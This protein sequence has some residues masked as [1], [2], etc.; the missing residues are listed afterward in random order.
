MP[1]SSPAA[2]GH[3]GGKR[4]Y[5]SPVRRERAEHTQERVSQA[6][7]GLFADRG[8]AR[9]SVRDIANAAGVAVE[10]VYAS[11]PK[12][13]VFL[14]AFELSLRGTLDGTPLLELDP[15]RAAA[16]ARSLAE[17]LTVITDFV[18]AANARTVRLWR[19]FVEAANGDPDVARAYADQ[20]TGMRRQ[21]AEV[22]AF[23]V[24]RQ[25]C[26]P[27]R[28]PQVTLDAVWATLH[29]SQYDL[30]VRHAGW[31]HERYQ[32]WLISTVTDLLARG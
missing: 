25:L 18:V 1:P 31:D 17:F 9:T 21:G 3:D 8:Y 16:D 15:V 6:A 27:P 10:T 22:L 11:G 28:A 13:A 24:E 12:S 19:A 14:R 23:A 29:P 26:D 4:P 30:L 20:M 2:A 5:Q 7:A 32:T